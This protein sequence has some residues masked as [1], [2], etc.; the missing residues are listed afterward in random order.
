MCDGFWSG[1]SLH[2][3][4]AMISSYARCHRKRRRHPELVV[5]IISFN[6]NPQ[7]GPCTHNLHISLPIHLRVVYYIYYVSNTIQH[8]TTY[9]YIQ[10]IYRTCF[11]C[12]RRIAFEM[13][14]CD[15]YKATKHACDRD[16]CYAILHYCTFI[17]ALLYLCAPLCAAHITRTRIMRIFAVA[18]AHAFSP[19]K[20]A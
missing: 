7:R 19:V 14:L 9:M 10:H 3:R 12:V 4:D 1:V 16:R 18:R 6:H 5:L 2:E 11:R 8:R 20:R 13:K 15:I 17:L